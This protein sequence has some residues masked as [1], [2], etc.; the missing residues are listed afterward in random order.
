MPCTW[1]EFV[2]AY[3]VSLAHDTGQNSEEAGAAAERGFG[4][5]GGGGGGLGHGGRWFPPGQAPLSGGNKRNDDGVGVGVGEE[6]SLA[7]GGSE[8]SG[9]G[10]LLHRLVRGARKGGNGTRA[11]QAWLARLEIDLL[12]LDGQRLAAQ[13]SLEA[14]EA[15][16]QRA[17]TLLTE[18]GWAESLVACSTYVIA[19]EVQVQLHLRARVLKQKACVAAAE[20]WLASDDGHAVWRGEVKRLLAEDR[21]VKRGEE[22]REGLD[23]K[24]KRKKGERICSGR[25]GEVEGTTEGSTGILL[26]FV[27]VASFAISSY[28]RV[29]THYFVFIFALRALIDMFFLNFATGCY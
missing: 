17:S 21:Q 3:T 15:T 20:T 4:L 19:A 25:K 13:G 27:L 14:A 26:D 8:A 12:T 6:A 11:Y 2:A 7:S 9:G 29:I 22:G 10:G 5:S 16:L 28:F 24:D 1:E 18:Q 23:R